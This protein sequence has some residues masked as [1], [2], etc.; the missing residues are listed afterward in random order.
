M[1]F[2]MLT[3]IVLPAFRPSPIARMKPHPGFERRNSA[4]NA[5]SRHNL[6]TMT[7]STAP[8]L[9]RPRAHPNERLR[10]ELLSL[11][12]PGLLWWR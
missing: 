7:N 10:A 8:R 6:F 12:V 11:Q 1:T 3:R 5:H 9:Q 4:Q 2:R